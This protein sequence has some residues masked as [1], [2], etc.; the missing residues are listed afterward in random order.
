MERIGYFS[1]V[2]VVTFRGDNCARIVEESV[3]AFAYFVPG[4]MDAYCRL[5]SNWGVVMVGMLATFDR[6]LVENI[7]YSIKMH[8]CI[9]RLFKLIKKLRKLVEDIL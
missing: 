2:N 4:L 7:E 5:A 6:S 1:N 8:D 9:D 3:S